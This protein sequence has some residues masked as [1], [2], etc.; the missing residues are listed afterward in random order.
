MIST[1]IPTFNGASFLAEAIASIRA[2]QCRD[3]E[4]IVVDD[5]STDET[6]SVAHAM[7]V[8]VIEQPHRGRPAYGRNVGLGAARGEFIAFL[9]QDDLWAPDKVT[10]QMER[11]VQDDSLQV[12]WGKTQRMELSRQG[13]FAPVDAPLGYRLL[14]AALFRRRVF[15]IVGTFDESMRYFGDDTDWFLRAR[16]QSVP[17]TMLDDLT[18]YWR[19]H[20]T[21]ASHANVRNYALGYDH[22]LAEVVH[23]AL[24]RRRAREAK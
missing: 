11:F 1:I 7:D 8:Y 22:A 14:S 23:N 13:A 20:T 24:I 15:D 9:D 3:L 18:L 12:V 17:M 21:N 2:N 6:V 16:E 10:R 19:I 5:G 4:I